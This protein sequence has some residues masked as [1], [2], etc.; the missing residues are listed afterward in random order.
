MNLI[1]TNST[2][3]LHP[4]SARPA[5]PSRSTDS[6]LTAESVRPNSRKVRSELHINRSTSSCQ[7]TAGQTGNWRKESERY[8]WHGRR[9][10]LS[11]QAC[12]RAA[13]VTC[14]QAVVEP[15]NNF[16]LAQLLR[17]LRSSRAVVPL[18]F[19]SEATQDDAATWQHHPQQQQQRQRQHHTL[20]CAAP[21]P[22]RRLAS[23]RR[24]QT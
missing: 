13:A 18:H 9:Y 2:I 6:S 5:F 10:Q 12:N 24:L 17:V 23:L 20:T 16:K 4:G 3:Q 8:R 14:I 1:V 15:L 21:V 11:S 7:H 22:P 19:R